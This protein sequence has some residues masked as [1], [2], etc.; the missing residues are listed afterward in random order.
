MAKKIKDIGENMA[1][2]IGFQVKQI[3]DEENPLSVNYY[4]CGSL[5]TMILSNAVELEECRVG[6][7]GSLEVISS[8]IIVSS[9]AR[10]KLGLFERTI[11]DLDIMNVGN[12]NF[13]EKA[14]ENRIK[15]E[16]TDRVLKSTSIKM[17]KKYEPELNKLFGGIPNLGNDTQE[18]LGDFSTAHRIA[19]VRT[20]SGNVLYISSPEA[21]IAH[22]LEETILLANEIYGKGDFTDSDKY[23][24]DIKDLATSI[25]GILSIYDKKELIVKVKETLDE[26][27]NNSHFRGCKK[28]IR[29]IFSKINDDMIK[30][31]TKKGLSEKINVNDL[32]HILVGILKYDFLQNPV[33]Q[34]K[35]TLNKR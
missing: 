8:K 31:V 11:G 4:F 15:D 29:P 25:Y 10:E 34:S 17:I 13:N 26:K 5:A 16:E 27:K 28:N 20:E 9:L 12:Y 24:K 1:R 21:I 7:N 2:Y 32:T 23:I 6:E 14:D 3:G 35:E 18:G 22:K 19:R 33:N 30:Y